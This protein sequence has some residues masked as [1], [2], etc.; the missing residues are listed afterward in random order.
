MSIPFYWT[1]TMY[2]SFWFSWTSVYS[3]P[4][5]ES[6][7][8]QSSHASSLFVEDFLPCLDC[9]QLQVSITWEPPDEICL[10]ILG[11]L[12][13]K[14]LTKI[15]NFDSNVVLVFYLLCWKGLYVSYSE[16]ANYW[17]LIK[18]NET[19]IMDLPPTM[20]NVIDW[21]KNINGFWTVL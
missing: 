21:R 15:F 13:M 16:H 5:R 10:L 2:F 8:K 1:I 7:N 3:L 12:C 14:I 11:N 9:I 6:G 4:E 17:V 19:L 18:T 20:L